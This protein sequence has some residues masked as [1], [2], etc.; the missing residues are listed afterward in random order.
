M[1]DRRRAEPG[2]VRLGHGPL[3]RLGGTRL[4]PGAGRRPTPTGSR[5]TFP[6]RSAPPAAPPAPAP[7]TPCSARWARCSG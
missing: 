5:S 2:P 4:H 1:D 3:R 6:T 7:P